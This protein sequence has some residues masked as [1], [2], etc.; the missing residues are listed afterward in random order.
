MVDICVMIGEYGYSLCQRWSFWMMNCLY[1]HL[2]LEVSIDGRKLYNSL[3][4]LWI[5][6]QLIEEMGHC[7]REYFGYLIEIDPHQS[8]ENQ[9]I[10]STW[11]IVYFHYLCEDNECIEVK[12]GFTFELVFLDGQLQ[13]LVGTSFVDFTVEC[14]CTW[15]LLDLFVLA[16]EI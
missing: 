3:S 2:I 9:R 13:L 1:C 4:C 14:N 12:V 16:L 8:Q 6:E 5:R 15:C 11:E 7:W 10:D